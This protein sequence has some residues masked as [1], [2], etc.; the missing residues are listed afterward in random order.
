MRYGTKWIFI[1]NNDNEERLEVSD[2]FYK[3]VDKND[4][5]ILNCKKGNFGYDV[6]VKI[7][8]KN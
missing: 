6:V 3:S 7:S 4:T 2:G 8:K 5:V 1:Y